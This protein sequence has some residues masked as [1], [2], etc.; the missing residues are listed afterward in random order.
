MN[1]SE[2][3]TFIPACSLEGRVYSPVYLFSKLVNSIYIRVLVGPGF[4]LNLLCLYVLSRPRLS[5][6]STTIVFLRF[7]AV[8]DIL[9]V[10]TK[11]IRAELNYQSLEKQR[12]ISFLVPATCKT[13]FVLMNG[14]ISMGMWTIVLMSVEKA[15]AVSYPLKSSI[16]LTK[17]RAF[18]MCTGTSFV[19]LLVNLAFINLSGIRLSR[20]RQ[21]YCGL[22]KDSIVIDVITASILPIGLITAVNIVI[23][24]VLHRVS[25]KSFNWTNGED[26]KVMVD[27]ELSSLKNVS[28]C[29][30]STR[31]DPIQVNK[32]RTSA[33]VT[34]ML[35]AVTLSL[36]IFNI[37]NTLIFLIAKI[38]DTR[39][40]LMGR[41]CSEIPDR[42]ITLYKL[43][44]YFSVVQD[45]LSD[46][47]HIVNF[48]L[49]CL[50]GKKF[51][52]IFIAE[53][54]HFLTEI[55]LIKRKKSNDLSRRLG[56]RQSHGSYILQRSPRTPRQTLD[57]IH[58][59]S[60]LLTS[61]NR[62]NSG[63]IN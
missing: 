44:F 63:T 25:R 56:P 58:R 12:N 5:S 61:E 15:V 42:D 30:Y 54:R 41:S 51:R 31:I 49:Y 36:I 11:Y 26:K 37:P 28:S 13:L 53:V 3:G 14:F 8:F 48:F 10:V 38:Y 40:L 43:G 27:C 55:H 1:T 16:W 39:T 9:A 46:L 7:L 50:A 32:R 22:T 2:N 6:K 23:T 59:K 52:S 18:Y 62:L 29:R 20:K 35:L 17:R 45:I 4:C 57:T 19:L 60:N 24:V 34:R 21:K 33:Q 47:P